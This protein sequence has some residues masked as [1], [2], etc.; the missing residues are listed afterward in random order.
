VDHCRIDISLKLFEN[1]LAIQAFSEMVA[2]VPSEGHC[3]NQEMK[4][5]DVRNVTRGV[6]AILDVRIEEAN[7]PLLAPPQGG[8]FW[9]D[10]YDEGRAYWLNHSMVRTHACGAVT[11]LYRSGVASLKKP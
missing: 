1:R 8:E 10:F 5:F 3:V 2:F 11:L 7:I 9:R 6:H 4:Q